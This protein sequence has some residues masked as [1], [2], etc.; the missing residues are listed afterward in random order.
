MCNI[1]VQEEEHAT[2]NLQ[3]Y[4]MGSRTAAVPDM[5]MPCVSVCSSND[6]TRAKTDDSASRWV[7]GRTPLIESQWASENAPRACLQRLKVTL[8]LGVSSTF[9]K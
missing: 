8:S 5:Y 4:L 3:S 2:L 6:V 1:S 9:P 7:V